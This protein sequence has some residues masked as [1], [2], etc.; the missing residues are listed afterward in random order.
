MQ[1]RFQRSLH[2]VIEVLLV[3]AV[4]VVGNYVARQYFVRVDLT[5]DREY[6]VSSAT[7]GILEDLDDVVSV[8]AYF[9][10]DLPPRLQQV[11][12]QVAD[13]LD[14]YRS[15]GGGRVNVEWIDPAKDPEVEQ[16]LRF[17]GIPQIQAQILEKDQLQVVNVYMGIGVSYADKRQGIPIVQDTYTLEYD[18]TS[19]ILRV[20]LDEEKVLGFLAGHGEDPDRQYQGIRQ[21]LGEQ[22]NVKVVD[23]DS[24]RRAVPEDVN[25]LI[26]AGPQNVPAREKYE[27]DQFIMRG[28]RAI[29]MI[30]AIRLDEQ[31][32][33]RARPVVS[34]LEDLL[35][36]Y[37]VRIQK[38]LVRDSRFNSLAA[39]SQGFIQYTVPYPFWPKISGPFLSADHVTTNRLE[40]LVLP[41]PAPLK[42]DVDV[43]GDDPLIVALK[44]E[45]RGRARELD[46][47]E[48]IKEVPEADSAA[49]GTEETAGGEEAGGE[50]TAA[51]AR[52]LAR[53]SPY[54]ELQ[55]GQFDISPDRN[56]LGS[57]MA[58]LGKSYVMAV[59]ID[60]RFKSLY[61]GKP[62][63]SADGEEAGI[64]STAEASKLAESPET[65]IIVLGTSFFIQDNFLSQFPENAVFFQN[66][67]DDLTLGPELIGI[68]SRGATDRPLKELS[69]GGKTAVRT[70]VTLGPAV[71]VILLGVVR[72]I[73]RRQRRASIES[74]LRSAA[75]KA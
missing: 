32:G 6:T 70:L 25:T 34:G 45:E 8:R 57:L 22:Y 49:A 26:V 66:A 72:R 55:T 11:R 18:L 4:L 23:L 73:V 50:G 68:R 47:S 51:K 43:E 15:F 29:F 12:R 37:G 69:D 75:Q 54:S 27:I 41:W 36:G 35:A 17:L 52:I 13:I 56:P 3:L 67:V 24:G 65:Q 39:F 30:D 33:L 20:T 53:S 74:A 60:G 44:E 64:D 63:P 16:Q 62:V 58:T 19:A 61:A 14:E 2:L 42:L 38:S 71:L 59:A 10:E 46:G 7:K 40:S 48:V 5:A 9:S 21:L 1:G 31:G 28:G